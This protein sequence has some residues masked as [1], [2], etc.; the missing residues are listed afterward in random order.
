MGVVPPYSD[1][2]V[3][4]IVRQSERR[5]EISFRHIERIA[6]RT[7]ESARCVVGDFGVARLRVKSG[8]GN[9]VCRLPVSPGDG[10]D[11]KRF[12]FP[13]RSGAVYAG[14]QRRLGKAGGEELSSVR[15]SLSQK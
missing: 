7:E 15:C 8:R 6:G 1:G 2:I 3:V 12:I 9:D 14:R 4:W 5:A 10:S 13:V 11:I